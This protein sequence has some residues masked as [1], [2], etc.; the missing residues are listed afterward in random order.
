MILENANVTVLSQLMGP[1]PEEGRQYRIYADGV[2][3]FPKNLTIVGDAAWMVGTRPEGWQGVLYR[4]LGGGG[5][6]TIPWARLPDGK[7]LVGMILENRSNMGN[8]KV[9]CAMG[10]MIDPGETRK[11]AQAREDMEEGGLDTQDAQLLPGLGVVQDRLFY[12]ARLE[13]GEGLH[14]YEK[15]YHFNQ[16][17]DLGDGTWRAKPGLV[18][19]KKESQVLFLPIGEAA[20]K[21]ADSVM[22]SAILKLAVKLGKV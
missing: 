1:L 22:L 18:N 16:L 10:G 14:C 4:E 11:E 8:E 3:I 17:E 20:V 21:T 7:V 12:V 19:H 9:W 15:Q 2:E 6:V 5:N 13:A